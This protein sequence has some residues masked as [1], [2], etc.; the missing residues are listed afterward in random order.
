MSVQLT[1][2]SCGDD[3]EVRSSR[4]NE[5]KYCSHDCYAESLKNKED[6]LC[7][8]CGEEF[9]VRP[10]NTKVYC[11]RACAGKAKRNRVTLVCEWC[12]ES[13]EQNKCDEERSRFCSKGCRAKGVADERSLLV[14]LRCEECGDEYEVRPHKV[15]EQKYC[16]HECYWK[17]KQQQVPLTCDYCGEGYQEPPSRAEAS[18][19]C[20]ARCMYDSNTK[21]VS[22]VCKECGDEYVCPLHAAEESNYCSRECNIE[23]QRLRGEGGHQYYGQNWCRMRRVV[24]NRDCFRCRRCGMHEDECNTELHVHHIVPLREF[25]EPEEANTPSNLVTVCPSCHGEVEGDVEAGRALL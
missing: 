5:A 8:E 13:Y 24:R 22:L 25:D 9:S 16:S 7:K 21:A 3:F 6:R 12:G 15:D 4:S 2:E 1:C 23:S 18:R 17:S 11:S 20:S 19:F 10:S 14:S